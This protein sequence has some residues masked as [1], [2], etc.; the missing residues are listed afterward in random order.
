M[1]PESLRRYVLWLVG[2]VNERRIKE[3]KRTGAFTVE[4]FRLLSFLI[5]W[6]GKIVATPHVLSQVSDLAD[7]PGKELRQMRQLFKSVVEQ[8]E[9]FYE[10][11]R[12]LVADPAFEGHGLTDAA[13]ATVCS[14]GILV[15]TADVNLQLALQRRGADALNFNHVRQLAWTQT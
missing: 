10:T 15:L 3:F 8:I 1:F 14:Q 9:E 12:V 13:I 6:F 5:D 4:D 11:S 7:L 2:L